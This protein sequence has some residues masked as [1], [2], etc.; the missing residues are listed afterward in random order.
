VNKPEIAAPIG[1]RQRLLAEL[2]AVIVDALNLRH[3]DAAHIKPETTFG[4]EGLNLDSVDILE[5]IVA[6]E[7]KY[8]VKV[9]DP[10]MG[11]RYFSSL[12]GV[13]DFLLTEK[14]A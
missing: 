3:L 9:K 2:K 13:A 6:V 14:R 4:P 11:R 12:A 8:K 7:Q 5:V 1:D 10:D